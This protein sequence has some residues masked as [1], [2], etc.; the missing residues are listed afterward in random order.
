MGQDYSFILTSSPREIA[1]ARELRK[2]AAL[3][4][5]RFGSRKV[6]VAPR[7]LFR[8]GLIEAPDIRFFV[9]VLVISGDNALKLCRH[10]RVGIA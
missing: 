6:A 1:A 9:W 3:K 4:G 2:I 5:R 8:L 10:C 7:H